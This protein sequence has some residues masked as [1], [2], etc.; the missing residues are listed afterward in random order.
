MAPWSL[1]IEWNK[2]G[3]YEPRKVIEMS[4]DISNG[5]NSNLTNCSPGIYFVRIGTTTKKM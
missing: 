5:M 2:P 4:E 1:D 3:N